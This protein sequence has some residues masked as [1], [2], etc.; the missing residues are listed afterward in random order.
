M[1]AY[2]LVAESRQGFQPIIAFSGERAS[3]AVVSKVFSTE[4]EAE[5][6]AKKQID[7]RK[8]YPP[9]RPLDVD[10]KSGGTSD[11]DP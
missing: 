2:P 3:C 10:A 1:T 7:E 9:S 6:F 11:C 5:S 8:I 4:A